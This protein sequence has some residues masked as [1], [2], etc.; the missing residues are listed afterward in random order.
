MGV[1]ISMLISRVKSLTIRLF[2]EP[3]E[4]AVD[5]WNWLEV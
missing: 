1:L 3:L 2:G 5:I 4:A